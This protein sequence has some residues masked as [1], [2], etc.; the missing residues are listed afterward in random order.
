[1]G[2]LIKVSTSC[3][4]FIQKTL[5]SDKNWLRYS[6]FSVISRVKLPILRAWPIFEHLK[7]LKPTLAKHDN[8]SK[9]K[10]TSKSETAWLVEDTHRK[11]VLISSIE[12]V[13]IFLWNMLEKSPQYRHFTREIAVSENAVLLFLTRFLVD[14]LLVLESPLNFRVKRTSSNSGLEMW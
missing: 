5:L 7:I 12:K 1:M 11:S 6:S 3:F 8:V 2:S 9:T 14:P 10:K 4:K 13:S